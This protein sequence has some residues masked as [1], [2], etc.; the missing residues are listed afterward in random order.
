MNLA[1]VG[2]CQVAAFAQS[3]SSLGVAATFSTGEPEIQIP[4]TLTTESPDQLSEAVL[5]ITTVKSDG[6]VLLRVEQRAAAV[7]NKQ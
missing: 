4:A 6:V 7:S 5:T 1:H 2:A 3:G